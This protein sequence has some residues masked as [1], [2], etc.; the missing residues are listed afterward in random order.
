QAD[1][2]TTRTYGGTGLGLA[3]S[4]SLVEKMGGRIWVEREPGKGS[5][6]HFHARFGLQAEPVPRRMFLRDELA[7]PRVLVVDDNAAAREI[8]TT[9]THALG[10]AV[11]AARDGSRALEMLGE[12]DRQGQ[13][14]DLVLMDWK[15]PVMDGVSTVQQLQSL[16]PRHMPAVIMVT[17]YGREEALGSAKEKD[18]ALDNVL[19]KPVT[20]STLLEAL[21]AALGKGMPVERRAQANAEVDAAAMAQL[22]GSR[23]L[24]VEDNDLNQELARDLLRKANVEVVIAGNGQEAL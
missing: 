4:K 18:V 15:M 24:L 21:R 9:M 2:S 8:L 19:T 17:A 7:G 14:Y 12:A 16:H 13:P 3:I 6:F 11:D 22:A 5:T 23:V 1:T 10:P 20:P